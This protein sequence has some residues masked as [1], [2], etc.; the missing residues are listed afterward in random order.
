[1]M[2]KKIIFLVDD[3]CC[4]GCIDGCREI[5]EKVKGI[6]NIEFHYSWPINDIEIDYD[7]NMITIDEIKKVIDSYGNEQVSFYKILDIKE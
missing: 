1:M 5:L 6:N 2:K 7:S 4:E 3:L